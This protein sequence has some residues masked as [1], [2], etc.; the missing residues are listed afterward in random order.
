MYIRR[1]RNKYENVSRILAP[2]HCTRIKET[3][4]IVMPTEAYRFYRLR[5]KYLQEYSWTACC[6]YQK[7]YYPKHSLVFAQI[8]MRS[9]LFS[10]STGWKEQRPRSTNVYVLCRPRKGIRQCP[11]AALWVVL[12]KLRCP[13]KFVRLLRLLHDDMT[14]CV[15]INGVQSE[16]FP[17]TCGVKQGCVLAPTLFALYFAVVVRE[18]INSFPLGWRTF[19]Y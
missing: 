6:L 3:D 2:A 5:G 12:A 17:V 9:Y 19:Q 13:D 14:C 11:S 16:F 8:N 10:S 18:T 7:Q 4:P 1:I 15:T